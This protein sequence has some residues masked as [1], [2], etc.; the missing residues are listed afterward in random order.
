M[1]TITTQ[2][3]SLCGKIKPKTEYTQRKREC[4]ECRRVKS[5][6]YYIANREK[7]LEYKKDYREQN[8]DKLKAKTVCE[9]G[10]TVC[11]VGIER[12]KQS[13]KHIDKLEGNVKQKKDIIS[14]YAEDGGL[15]KKFVYVKR[16]VYEEFASNRSRMLCT[17]Y[18]ILKQMNLI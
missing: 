1:E 2:E 16:E 9:C 5:R 10:V 12:H 14:Y 4:Q 11:L 3:C 18:K 6:E 17:N 7:V 15:K 8:E 13:K